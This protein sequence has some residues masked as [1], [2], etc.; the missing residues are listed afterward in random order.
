MKRAVFQEIAE[1]LTGFAPTSLSPML[2]PLLLVVE[3]LHWCDDLSLE[4]LLYFTRQVTGRP[5]LVLMTYRNDEDHPA[6]THFLATLERERAATELTLA[7]LSAEETAAMIRAI[8][9]QPQPVRR[10][11]VEAVYS[12]TD[13]NPFFVEEI[14]KSLVA[15]GEIFFADGAWDRKP[16]AQL[17]LPRTIRDAVQQRTAR[18]GS[19]ARQALNLA[20]VAG[21]RFD[22][23]VLL[24][25]CGCEAATL[26]D[27]IRQMIHAQLVAEESAN[28]YS[29]RHALTQQA[30]YDGLLARERRELHAAIAAQMERLLNDAVRSDSRLSDLAYHFHAAEVWDKSLLYSSQVGEAALAAIAPRAAV[31]HFTRALEAA[32]ALGQ[33]VPASLY[34]ARGRAYELLSEFE[35]ACADYSAAQAAARAAHDS[36]AEWR[37]L[38]DLGFLW[39]ERDYARGGEYYHQAL[40]LARRLEQP[41]TLAHSLNRVANWHANA[42]RPIEARRFHAEALDIFESLHDNDGI[43]ETLDLFVSACFMGGD[44][45]AGI[46]YAERAIPL[47]R[48]LGNRRGLAQTLSIFAI[49]GGNYMIESVVSADAGLAD[50]ERDGKEALTLA[51]EIGWRAGEAAILNIIAMLYGPFGFFERGLLAAS[52]GLTLA[53]EIGHRGWMATAHFALGC[54]YRDLLQTGEA[55]THAA[56]AF[57]LANEVRSLYFLRKASAYLACSRIAQGNLDTAEPLLDAVFPTGETPRTLGER[58]VV[59]ARAELALARGEPQVALA[60]VKQLAAATAKG[61]SAGVIPRLAHLHASALL[62]LGQ[63]REALNVLVPAEAY[64]RG[65]GLRPWRWKLLAAQ[66]AAWLALG[67]RADAADALAAARG[68]VQDLAVGITDMKLREGFLQAARRQMASAPLL[69]AEGQAKHRYDG[70]TARER[71]VAVLIAQGKTNREIADALI[72]SRRTVEVHIANMM[73]KLTFDSVAQIGAWGWAKGLA[74]VNAR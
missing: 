17:R 72:L 18:L 5:M 45:L 15:S 56:Q 14:L 60:Q 70:L 7:P 61:E 46:P 2:S 66:G 12:L 51:R 38:L 4:F 29:F 31:V 1:A 63:P 42:E 53:T 39:Q 32:S 43:A 28:Q 34:R 27:H 67:R 58:F 44:V 23:N 55:E 24:P 64:A 10:A 6:L 68:V 37:A 26:L 71:Q 8:F 33:A 59:M 47:M 25:L 73:T 19:G 74:D 3:D 21:R 49:R 50:C 54:L 11:F 36:E 65:R 22:F 35:A 48:E 13:G 57:A 62:A 20:A 16:L 69:S 52:E 9:E 30:I 41:A 40:D